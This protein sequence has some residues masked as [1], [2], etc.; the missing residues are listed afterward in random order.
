[1]NDPYAK[2][3]TDVDA[4]LL[5]VGGGPVGL[6]TALYAALAGM[7]VV[8]LESRPGPV[9][10]ACGEGLMP[11]ALQR[12]A[13]LGVDPSGH[14]FS[15][16]GYNDTHGRRVTAQ[17]PAHSGQGRGVRRTELNRALAQRSAAVGVQVLQQRAEEV[18]QGLDWVQSGGVRARWLAA[19]DGLHSPIRRQLALNKPG[20]KLARYGLRRHVQLAPWSD[21]VEVH[22]AAD[23]E[24]Y[25]TPIAADTVG[26]AVLT[27]TRGRSL[28]QWLNEFPDLARRIDG[29]EIASADR[30]AGPLEQRV[31][32]LVSG[33]VLLVGDA[34]GYVDALTGEGMAAGFAQAQQLVAAISAGA[35]QQY[36]LAAARVT[37][38]SRALTTGLLRATSLRP[39]RRAL[40]PAASAA[41]WAFAH[42][43]GKLA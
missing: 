17:F 43:V 12:L 29:A 38:T 16:I 15:G 20:R 28:N 3:G 37:R 5:V 14:A 2:S 13:S 41:P 18:Q 40:V 36:E 19:A 42:I 7:S 1:M 6:V 10:K 32:Q 23:A 30:G 34:A 4:D 21:L 26:I 31:S 8:V 25:V 22:W 33:R 35:P 24:C 27:S 9:D 11:S 39:V